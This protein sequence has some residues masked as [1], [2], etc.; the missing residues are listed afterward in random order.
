MSSALGRDVLGGK[1]VALLF[2]AVAVV[3]LVL[4]FPLNAV[5]QMTSLAFLVI[6]GAVSLGHLRLRAQTKARAWP[7]WTAVIVNAALFLALLADAVRTGPPST[8]I[9][10]VAALV[11]SFAFEAWYR[12]RHH[13]S[14]SRGSQQPAS[15]SRP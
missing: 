8:W 9:T 5:G 12:R 15:N 3:L 1:P 6:Y 13:P 7:L 2:S 10:L 14:V 4:F 11:G